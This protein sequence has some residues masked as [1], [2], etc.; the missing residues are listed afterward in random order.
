MKVEINYERLSKRNGSVIAVEVETLDTQDKVLHEVFGVCDTAEKCKKAFLKFWNTTH[1]VSYTVRVLS[2]HVVQPKPTRLG[3]GFYKLPFDAIALHGGMTL[4]LLLK[5][6]IIVQ[7][8]TAY[9]PSPG[10][11]LN[12]VRQLLRKVGV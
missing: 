10:R 1:S 12:D 2:A 5:L 8:G 6:G 11:T 3:Q 4:Q 7:Q 9:H